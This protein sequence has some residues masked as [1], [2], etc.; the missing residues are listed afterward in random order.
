MKLN[1]EVFYKMAIYIKCT[2]LV[3]AIVSFVASN[4]YFELSDGTASKENG[5]FLN[6]N[7]FACDRE[8]QCT[9]VVKFEEGNE[10]Q[11]VNGEQELTKITRKKKETWKRSA[12]E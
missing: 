11:T 10:Y 2:F 4:S 9:H 1:L 8:N 12:E 5:L 3:F 6:E 7:I